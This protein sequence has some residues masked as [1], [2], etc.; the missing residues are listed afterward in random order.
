LD[1]FSA[2]L[3]KKYDDCQKLICKSTKNGRYDKNGK[4]A[5]LNNLKRR[6]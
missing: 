4:G 5:D 6:R 3:V 1:E 2:K